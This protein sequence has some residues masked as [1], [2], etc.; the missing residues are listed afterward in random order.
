MASGVTLRHRADAI[1]VLGREEPLRGLLCD[2]HPQ[3]IALL[4]YGSVARGT[5]DPGSDL[6]VLEL[7]EKNPRSYRLG[8]ANITQYVPAH[9]HA[10]ATQ[11]SLFVLHLKTDGVTI[12]DPNGTL[13]RALKAYVAP[14]SYAHI[15][16]QLAVAGGALDPVSSDFN[17]YTDGLARLGVYILRTAAYIR[18]IELGKPT[19]DINRVAEMLGEPSL[20]GALALRRKSGFTSADVAALRR[21]IQWMV[22]SVEHNP[23][24]TVLAY[25]VA[26]STRSDLASLFTAVM[27]GGDGI[28][29]STLT[30][31]PF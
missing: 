9:L 26:N 31:P 12:E 18:A 14:S 1:A 10:M 2:A 25:G 30:L 15:W 28:D 29:Y 13:A 11:G 19:F 16:R 23:L 20:A 27:D 21:E 5:D 3:R 24:G 4:I 6:D 22:P 7:V 8:R 17:M